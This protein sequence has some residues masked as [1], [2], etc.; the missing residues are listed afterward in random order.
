MSNEEQKSLIQSSDERYNTHTLGQALELRYANT[1][2]NST[3]VYTN[4]R[5]LKKIVDVCGPVFHNYGF[6]MN[7]GL[8]AKSVYVSMDEDQFLFWSSSESLIPQ[9]FTEQEFDLYLEARREAAL[10]K[11]L[12]IYYGFGV[13]HI[14]FFKFSLKEL[15]TLVVD[16]KGNCF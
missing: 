3:S 1:V 10:R 4:V 6:N 14:F 7:L 8:Y 5:L 2:E 15:S 12:R 13:I 16:E 9:G 11:I